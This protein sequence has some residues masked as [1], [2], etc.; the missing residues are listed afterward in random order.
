MKVNPFAFAIF[1]L[2]LAAMDQTSLPDT[3]S[4]LLCFNIYTLH[5]SFGRYYQAAFSETGLTYP[6]FVILMALE[7]D[8]PM[9]VSDL[10]NRAGVEAN[11][12]SPL[13]KK[14]ASFGTITRERAEADERRVV[15]TIAPFGQEVLT[16]ARAVIAEGFA[17]LQIDAAKMSEALTFLNIVRGKVEDADPPKLNLDGLG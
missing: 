11:T 3:L 17:E 10:S 2:C 7:R 4:E 8:G 13:L 14:M 15:V 12:L 5:R 16:R 1:C 6:K 9:S